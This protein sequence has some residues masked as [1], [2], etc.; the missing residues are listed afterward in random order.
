MGCVIL[1][2]AARGS[3]PNV[4]IMEKE[5]TVCITGIGRGLGRALVDEYL[6]RDGIRVIGVT[7]DAGKAVPPLES[8]DRFT[9]VEADIAEEGGREKVRTAVERAGGV[10]VLI[11]NAGVLLFKPFL[12]ITPDELRA[13]YEVN[14]F[15]P[16]HLTRALLP[17]CRS[18]HV[19]SLSSMGGVD[20]SLKFA[21]LSAY[22]SSKAALNNLTELLSAEFADT[23]HAFNCLAMGSV[24][25]E[26]F[27][28]AF[29]GLEAGVDAST[30]AKFV[31]DFGFQAPAVMRGKIIPVSLSNP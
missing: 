19:V 20:G 28:A 5:K 11:H 24:G 6:S 25:T 16:F 26:M 8:S 12:E 4:H 30:M 23:S 27:R 21:G 31:G 15:A 29:P 18:C 13:V 2:T 1:R 22:S 10:D 7:R 14:V 17:L 9:V 3:A